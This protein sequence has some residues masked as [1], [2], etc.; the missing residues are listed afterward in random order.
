MVTLA[1]ILL[2]MLEVLTDGFSHLRCSSDAWFDI[3]LLCNIVHNRQLHFSIRNNAIGC[4]ITASSWTQSPSPWA[5]SPNIKRLAC[6]GAATCT[7]FPVLLVIW[8][9]LMQPLYSPILLGFGG[10]SSWFCRN[11]SHFRWARSIHL[12]MK[13]WLW[14]AHAMPY[15]NFRWLFVGRLHDHLLESTRS[16]LFRSST[17]L[18]PKCSG[19]RVHF[20]RPCVIYISRW[21]DPWIVLIHS[22][23]HGIQLCMSFSTLALCILS[24]C[25]CCPLKV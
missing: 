13:L 2:G 24:G 8:L 21:M 3:A 6:S 25:S 5:L 18:Q 15:Q 11:G 4:R 22:V 1:F 10:T 16:S 7:A 19:N 20:L 9:P 23:H 14:C 12:L 17:P